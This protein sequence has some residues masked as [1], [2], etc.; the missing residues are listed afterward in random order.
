LAIVA[1]VALAAY[2]LSYINMWVL[3]PL[4]VVKHKR[5]GVLL[6]G[7]TTLAVFLLLSYAIFAGTLFAINEIA[8]GHA[9]SRGNPPHSS[10][11]PRS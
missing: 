5:L 3:T 10:T 1:Y 7:L 2:G 6:D 8:K 11:V 9:A 4:H